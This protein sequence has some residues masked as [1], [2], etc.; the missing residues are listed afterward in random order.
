MP[1]LLREQ[2]KTIRSKKNNKITNV[3]ETPF[4]SK[5]FLNYIKKQ[6]HFNNCKN[7]RKHQHC[8]YIICLQQ[9]QHN[10]HCYARQILH[11]NRNLK[12]QKALVEELKILH[13][14]P[15]SVLWKL[16]PGYIKSRI[17]K[18]FATNITNTLKYIQQNI[19]DSHTETC[20]QS[21]TEHSKLRR[22]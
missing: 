9:L 7:F 10:L 14:M 1:Q 8:N 15:Q 16:Q 20:E 11:P 4:T 2:Q 6:Y 12:E 19:H 13:F 17:L 21:L 5:D 3:D 18:L 22:K